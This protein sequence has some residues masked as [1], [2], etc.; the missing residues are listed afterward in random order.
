[1]PRPPRPILIAALLAAPGFATPQRDGPPRTVPGWGQ[2]VDPDGDCRI[3]ADGP[4][5]TIAVPGT[6]HDLVAE[7][8][9]MNAPRVLGDTAGDFIAQVKVA[10]N[11]RHAGRRTSDQSLAYHGAG[12][13]LWQD[14]RT[15]VRLER[16][17]IVREDG[18]V[19]HYANFELRKDG[20]LDQ[21]GGVEIPDR[22]TYLRLERRGRRVIGAVSEDGVRW[23]WLKPIA[24][25][26]A[27][28]VK[29]GVAAVSTSSDPLTAEFSE[30]EVYRKEK[31]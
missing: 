5:L 20:R 22:A 4:R 13:L 28:E 24:A 11:I 30:L 27:A 18:G 29:L 23:S 14:G 12:L 6:R 9:E 25:D 10:G 19:V 15:Y 31:R 7:A 17:A 21:G 16:A 1:M 2:A 26:L 8:G 3:S